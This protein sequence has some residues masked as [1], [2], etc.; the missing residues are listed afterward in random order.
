MRGVFAQVF[1]DFGHA[2]EVL[3]VDGALAL[4]LFSS[5]FGL[6]SLQLP[7]R[8]LLLACFRVAPL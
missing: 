3:D 1:C 6:R 7:P 2:F 4:L 8:A 5:R